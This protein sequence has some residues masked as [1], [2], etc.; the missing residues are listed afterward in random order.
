MRFDLLSGQ[1]T[2]DWTGA[3]SQ[4]SFQW[5]PQALWTA[6]N[7]FYL[8]DSITGATLQWEWESNHRPSIDD[9]DNYIIYTNS[10]AK[11]RAETYTTPDQNDIQHD[12]TTQLNRMLCLKLRNKITCNETRKSST[13]SWSRR[14]SSW[15]LLK[16]ASWSP[17]LANSGV[18]ALTRQVHD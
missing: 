12:P 5:V 13:V 14:R 16:E 2:A 9:I 6:G 10:E 17:C 1:P 15:G 7:C 18:S 3:S 11:K 8:Q 4:L